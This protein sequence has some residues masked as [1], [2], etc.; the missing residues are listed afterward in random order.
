M[1]RCIAARRPRALRALALLLLA[2][3]AACDRVAEPFGVPA[4]TSAAPPTVVVDSS[5]LA[6]TA[7][8]RPASDAAAA[9]HAEETAANTPHAAA[10]R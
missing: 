2:P 8:V 9:A 5:G 6:V 10:D 4:P 1:T 7:R 3:A